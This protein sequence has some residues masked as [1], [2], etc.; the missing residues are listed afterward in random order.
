[1]YGR[2]AGGQ[3]ER[4]RERQQQDGADGAAGSDADRGERGAEDRAGEHA[5][6]VGAPRRQRDRAVCRAAIQAI[7][8]NAELARIAGTGHER[9]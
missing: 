1:M 3:R 6:D 4:L 2:G 8:L 5:S 7:D 9:R